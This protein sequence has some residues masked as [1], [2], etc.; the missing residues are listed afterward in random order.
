VLKIVNEE[1]PAQVSIDKHIWKQSQKNN[2]S[3]R[4]SFLS[5][6][7]K[8][9]N[10]SNRTVNRRKAKWNKVLCE[11]SEVLFKAKHV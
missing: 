11:Y 10:L 6:N 3:E 1:Y 4:R 7:H 8:T 2:K 9:H 5:L